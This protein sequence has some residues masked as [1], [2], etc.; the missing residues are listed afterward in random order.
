MG[1]RRGVARV[2]MVGEAL[3]RLVVI[4]MVVVSIIVGA[5][6]VYPKGFVVMFAAVRSIIKSI[7]NNMVLTKFTG[8]RRCSL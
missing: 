8:R 5:T 6:S 1:N 3:S 7:Q 2:T 4:T